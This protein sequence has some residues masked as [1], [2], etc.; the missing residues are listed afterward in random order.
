R[1]WLVSPSLQQ[2]SMER[3]GGPSVPS[4]ATWLPR[5][6]GGVEALERRKRPHL[7]SVL[8][9]GRSVPVRTRLHTAE[10]YP[11]FTSCRSPLGGRAT[12]PLT[13]GDISL[14]PKW[15]FV[16]Y[17]P[18]VADPA[19]CSPLVIPPQLHLPFYRPSNNLSGLF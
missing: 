4:P 1:V 8:S 7:P 18:Q 10:H 16:I 9:G 3:E 14:L 11:R 15:P 19:N 5:G 2:A 6:E 17:S 12:V 13:H